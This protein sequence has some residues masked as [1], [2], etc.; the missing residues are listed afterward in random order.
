VRSKHQLGIQDGFFRWRTGL[1]RCGFLFINSSTLG[2]TTPCHTCQLPSIRVHVHV[3]WHL[4]RN[5]LRLVTYLFCASLRPVNVGKQFCVS[6]ALFT[7]RNELCSRT[8]TAVESRTVAAPAVLQA[9]FSAPNKLR[10]CDLELWPFWPK[11]IHRDQ[12]GASKSSFV[13][14]HA[15]RQTYSYIRGSFCGHWWW[16]LPFL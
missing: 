6:S 15:K 16:K 5:P 4:N 11:I 2:C 8:Q 7:E 12:E 13:T 9:S 10:C 1:L 14:Y 3:T